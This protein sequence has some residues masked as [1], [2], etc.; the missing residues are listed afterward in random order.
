MKKQLELLPTLV[1]EL[2]QM[3]P[4]TEGL[5]SALHS[6]DFLE[7][8]REYAEKL[9]EDISHLT[10]VLSDHGGLGP[11]TPPA[12]LLKRANDYI[13]LVWKCIHNRRAERKKYDDAAPPT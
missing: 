1:R 10:R 3:L 11:E 4:D 7:A 12:V 6:K 5:A 9:E 13:G 8:E 2:A